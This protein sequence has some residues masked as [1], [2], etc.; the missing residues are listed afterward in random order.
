M[1]RSYCD[2]CN[3]EG[4]RFTVIVT[5]EPGEYDQIDGQRWHHLCG[6]CKSTLMRLDLAEF[7]ARHEQRPRSIDLP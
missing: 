6:D 1:D 2:N 3:E 4:A 7:I 5:A